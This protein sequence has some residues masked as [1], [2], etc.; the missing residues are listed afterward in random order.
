MDRHDVRRWVDA[1]E[2]AWRAAGT[3]GL[4]DC[5]PRT[6]PTARRRG[7]RRSRGSRRSASSGRRSARGRTRTS[8]WS[9]RWW[10]STATPRSSRAQVE[11]GGPEPARWRDLWVLRFGAG[12]ALPSL[13]G[14]AVRPG[15]AR[16]PLR[17][18]READLRRAGRSGRCRRR[19]GTRRRRPS[20]GSA[21][22]CAPGGRRRG[23]RPPGRSTTPKCCQE[24][25]WPA[26]SPTRARSSSSVAEA[27]AQRVCGTTRIRFT[28]SRCTPRT[29]AS[30]ACGVTRPPGLRKIF[31]SPGERPE[32]PQWGDPRVHAGDDRDAGM[33]DAVEPGEVEGLRE[34]LVRV[35]QVVEG[36]ARHGHEPSRGAE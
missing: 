19:T 34:L 6:R 7:R 27:I 10:P 14:V 16:R 1:Y 3:I 15:A 26:D 5:S 32:H 24:A 9:R 2:R 17:T 11:Y 18:D 28:C 8:R 4:A 13:R 36:V 20:R 23:A 12:R 29:S 25:S 33:G 22:G 21:G 31:A 35:Q 30:S